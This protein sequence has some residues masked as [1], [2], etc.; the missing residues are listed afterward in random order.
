MT[1][2][3]LYWSTDL[4]SWHHEAVEPDGFRERGSYERVEPFAGSQLRTLWVWGGKYWM[5]WPKGPPLA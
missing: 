5:H 1:A 2:S 4:K 3:D